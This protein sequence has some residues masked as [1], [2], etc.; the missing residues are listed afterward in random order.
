MINL[1]ELDPHR[2]IEFQGDV[3]MEQFDAGL[4]SSM[5]IDEFEEDT[6][7]TMRKK[8]IEGHNIPDSLDASLDNAS[9]PYAQ[10]TS[11]AVKTIGGN[12]LTVIE[13]V[14][15]NGQVRELG[16]P[17]EYTLTDK[18]WIP[19]GQ[20]EARQIM[21]EGGAP[22]FWVRGYFMNVNPILELQQAEEKVAVPL[23]RETL[24]NIGAQAISA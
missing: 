7:V 14:L 12:N 18:G 10:D 23:R 19:S 20:A 2:A 1:P 15:D 4:S 3:S 8:S 6:H 21:E 17:G 24:K 13:L 16:E 9:L 22:E 5:A 11:V